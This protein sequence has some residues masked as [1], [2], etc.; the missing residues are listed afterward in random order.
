MQIKV[1]VYYNG[2]N[3]REAARLW[4]ANKISNI[5]LK[6]KQVDH[7]EE[8]EIKETTK[9]YVAYVTEIFCTMCVAIFITS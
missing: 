5:H 6:I 2:Y 3:E 4:L 1:I 9:I 8:Q 7:D